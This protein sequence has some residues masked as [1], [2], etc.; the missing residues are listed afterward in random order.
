MTDSAEP[1]AGPSRNAVVS[2]RADAN[3]LRQF[4]MEY[5]QSH[6]FDKALAL[7][8]QGP[9]DIGDA[10]GEASAAANG[11][12]AIFRAPGPVPLE[13]N[14]KRNIP[15]AQAVSASTLSESITPEFEA[16]AKYII[17]QLQAK[18]QATNPGE[19]GADDANKELKDG[20]NNQDSLLD[21]SDRVEG[22]KSFRR[23]V[24]GGL[25]LWKPELDNLSF[26]LFVHTFLDLIHFGFLKTARDFFQTHASHHQPLHPQDISALAS[27][28]TKE[29]VQANPF[30]QRI[31]TDKYVVPLSRNTNDLVIQWLSGA[32][33][34]ED[35]E[36]GLH[37]AAGRA[38]E[39]IK[40]IVFSRISIKVTSTSVPLDEITIA[41]ASGLL[42]SALP[43]AM[44][45]E[46]FNTAT[47]LKLGPPPIT[48]KL[49]EQVIRT[50]QDEE[51]QST[52]QPNGTSSPSKA[53]LSLPN[54]HPNGDTNGDVEMS[55]PNQ[56]G[57]HIVKLE[58]EL[59]RNKD[60]DLVN[61]EEN[62]TLPPIPAVFRIPDLKREVEAIRD[63]RKMI[64]LGPQNNGE[65]KA[66]SSSNTVLPSVVAFTLFDQGESAASVEFSKDSSLM[67]VGSSESCIRLWSLKGEKLKK[68]TIDPS[69]GS[70]LEDDGEPF[71]KLI[72]HSGPVYSLSFDPLYG[73]ASAPSTLLSSSQDGTVRLWSLDTYSNLVVYRGHGKDPV[74]DVEWGPMGVYFATASRDRT[75]RLWSSDRVTPLR[76]YTGH[77]SDVNCVRF[78]PNSL[79][80]ATGSNDA[81]CRLWDVQRGACV[82]LF[83]GH[84]DAVTT[85][86]ISPDGKLLA[87]AGLDSSIWLWDLGSSRPIKKMYGHKSSIQS[88]SF[89]ADSSVI[90]SGGLDSTVRCWDVK[91]PGGEKSLNSTN[92]GGGDE[93]QGSL[94]MG[95]GRGNWEDEPHTSDLLATWLTKRTPILKTHYTPRN[96]C[97]VAGSFIPPSNASKGN[98]QMNG[99]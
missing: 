78:H 86:S 18:V 6:G 19:D 29:H 39:A 41:T 25:D 55:S 67:A 82:R 87:S 20:P 3:L 92:V 57:D 53:S 76:M 13:S 77:L 2:T 48:E 73:S 26:P 62:E 37:S 99:Q 30:C 42:A 34:D 85:M 44:P 49:K 54:G 22:Y 81:S 60:P 36:A 68:K 16:Q 28:S 98:Q 70:L 7:F 45:I 91:S 94:P 1:V 74:W 66:G 69:D 5:L 65:S 38:K 72:G 4:V 61:P 8:Q 9:S 23:W 88:L 59:E 35:W 33:L 12:E 56:T 75:A 80:L 47:D 58:P 64:R 51:P 83:M 93:L 97:M 71:R 17:E 14:V 90:I 52:Q 84:T 46:A 21:P 11:K 32:G 40:G 27:I 24:D 79:Y 31:I 89:S 43:S 63:K 15:Q 10:E 96:L 50:L 95:P